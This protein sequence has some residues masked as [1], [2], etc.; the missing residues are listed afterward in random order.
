MRASSSNSS[1]LAHSPPG[2]STCA[3]SAPG[4]NEHAKQHFCSRLVAS[5]RDPTRTCSLWTA[6][7]CLGTAPPLLTRRSVSGRND[8]VADLD[9]TLARA[10]K[11]LHRCAQDC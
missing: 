7:A 8:R 4:E 2:S 9:Q 6:N 5:A 1:K 3:T 11:S 10:E